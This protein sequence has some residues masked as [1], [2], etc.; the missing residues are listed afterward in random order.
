MIVPRALTN[1]RCLRRLAGV[2][3][4]A[5][6]II[7]VGGSTAAAAA[8]RLPARFFGI[9][10]GSTLFDPRVNLDQQLGAMRKA[11]TGS[12]RF[13]VYWSRAQPYATR[14]RVPVSQRGQFVSA[15][16]RPTAFA[17]LDRQILAYAK[18]HLYMIPTVLEAPTWARLSPGAQWSPPAHPIDYA[19]FVGALV[20]RY[21]TRGSFWT[22]HHGLARWAPT[23]WQ[24]WNEPAGGGTPEDSTYFW[25]GP[26]PYE[27]R[28]VE[29]L[30][31]SRR[32]VRAADPHARILLAGL[33]GA[34]WNA[35][36]ALY[37]Y[38]AGGSFD[39][40][41]VHPYAETPAHVLTILEYVRAVMASHHATRMPLL[42]TEAGW[43][44]SEGQPAAGSSG[45]GIET[46]VSRQASN[47]TG[48]YSLLAANRRK[49]NLQGI[50][51]FTWIGAEPNQ[52]PFEYAGLFRLTA[53]GEIQ[54]KPAYS[55]YSRILRRLEG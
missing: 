3:A 46:T 23:W 1:A 33:F 49:L 43:T 6:V 34:S 51:W 36:A 22:K 32:A 40:V 11:G 50:F 55:A 15:S 35:L 45:Q 26:K 41:A 12:I 20:K 44:S 9:A 5:V 54:A 37:R 24:I 53:S 18:H 38:G 25:D 19:R 42:V 4:S 21:G 14:L 39:G 31:L 2:L 10:A 13:P 29:M 48:E 8:P 52:D 30:R 16:G 27:P 47:L 17:Q 28:Y 7:A